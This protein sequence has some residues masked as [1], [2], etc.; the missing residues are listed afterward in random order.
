MLYGIPSVSVGQ[1]QI[2]PKRVKTVKISEGGA[3][4]ALYDVAP[5]GT[6]LIDWAFAEELM[7]TKSDPDG[8]NLA[9]LMLAIR[10][11]KWRPLPRTNP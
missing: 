1:E 8:V 3:S 6:V 9:R 5:D 11:G 10:D 7:A 4:L 2:N